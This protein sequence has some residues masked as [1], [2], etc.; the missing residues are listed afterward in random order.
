[1]KTR[2]PPPGVLGPEVKK[3]L[4]VGSAPCVYDDLERAPDWPL[5]V[6]NYA[7]LR[8]LGPI[9]LWCSLHYRLLV[10]LIEQREKMG[11]DMNFEAFTRVPKHT[12]HLQ[13]AAGIKIH[14]SEGVGL[15]RMGN[16][17]SGLYATLTA[18]SRGFE[19]LI[20]CGIPLEG[21]ETIQANEKIETRR[22]IREPAFNRFRRPWV[23]NHDYL[24][25]R[26][27]SM[28]GWTR[29]LLGGPGVSFT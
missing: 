29:E 12:N 9:E 6:I 4:V 20:L 1:M 21:D 8:H 27:R 23:V 5:I 15:R 16:G 3:A 2:Q 7:G 18:I 10:Q 11:G 25:K 17:S 24:A 28:S 14:R 26:V 13:A 19:R 22:S